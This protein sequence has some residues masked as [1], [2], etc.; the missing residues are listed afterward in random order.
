[1]SV[2]RILS[3]IVLGLYLIGL[4]FEC[5]GKSSEEN[6]M[7][8]FAFLMFCGFCLA[9]I[10]LPDE[11]GNAVIGRITSTSPGCFVAFMA[12]IMFVAPVLIFI[13]IKIYPDFFPNLF[14]HL[15]K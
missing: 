10:W 1:M 13:I 12:W 4:F 7:I 9:C 5:Q 3:L 11:M 2:S 15:L 8:V 14:L 6:F